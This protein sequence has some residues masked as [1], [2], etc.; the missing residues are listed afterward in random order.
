M[1]DEEVDKLLKMGII[2]PGLEDLGQCAYYSS[3]VLAVLLIPNGIDE[4]GRPKEHRL[5]IDYKQ[6][7]NQIKAAH[8]G[9]PQLHDFRDTLG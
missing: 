7:N 3:S 4:R 2:E 1:I 6:V 8:L 5:M 9:L